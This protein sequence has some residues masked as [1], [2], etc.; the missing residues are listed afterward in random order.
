MNDSKFMN[1]LDSTNDLFENFTSLVLIHSFPADNI[2]KKLSF[3]HVLHDKKEV[4]R[5]LDDL[6]KLDNIWMPD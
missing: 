2:I 6:I 5:S 4:F 1:I 3:L